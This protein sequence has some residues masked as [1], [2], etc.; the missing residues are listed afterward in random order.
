[1]TQTI[2][3]PDFS[4]D[5]CICKTCSSFEERV[6]A[7][8]RINPSMVVDFWVVLVVSFSPQKTSYLPYLP[9]LHP[10]D[11]MALS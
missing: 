8:S 4:V 11:S 10:F 7:V 5:S 2:I 6:V 1:M 9:P 3:S